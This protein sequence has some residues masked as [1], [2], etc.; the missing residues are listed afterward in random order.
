M[1][2]LETLREEVLLRSERDRAQHAASLAQVR[3][4]YSRLLRAR[5]G[6]LEALCIAAEEQRGG[7]RD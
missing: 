3:L 6:E 7:R 5:R 2:R 1:R 4:R